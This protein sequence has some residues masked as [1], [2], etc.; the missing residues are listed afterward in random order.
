MVHHLHNNSEEYPF[1][2][3]GIPLETR[4]NC[5]HYYGIWGVSASHIVQLHCHKVHLNEIG[6]GEQKETGF[7][8]RDGY[9]LGYAAVAC[10]MNLTIPRE[11]LLANCV[12]V[13]D[14]E[15]RCLGLVMFLFPAEINLNKYEVQ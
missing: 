3:M 1:H 12:V 4:Q 9:P 2:G 11:G 5:S 13:Q 8:N 14:V 7:H 6:E 10:E 15:S